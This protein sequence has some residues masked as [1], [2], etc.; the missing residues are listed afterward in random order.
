MNEGK[1]GKKS[2]KSA[3][4]ASKECAYLAAFVALLIVAQLCL[5]FLP[6]IEVVTVLFLSY[7]FTFGVRRGVFAATVFSLLRQLVFGF[8][9]TVLILYLLYYNLL[10]VVFGIFGKKVKESLKALWWLTLVACLGTVCFVM[11][12]NVLTPLW[13]RYS[14]EAAKAYFFSSLVFLLPQIICTAVTVGVLF[15]PLNRAFSL[16]KR[17]IIR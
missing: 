1:E 13:Y 4:R 14:W 5:S 12:D 3:I 9:P 6:G 7:A 2:K 17:G 15:F 10:A 8:Y 16:V 11:I